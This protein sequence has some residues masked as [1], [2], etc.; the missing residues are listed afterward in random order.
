M[1]RRE[2]FEAWAKMNSRDIYRRGATVCKG[3]KSKSKTY[4]S[5][6]KDEH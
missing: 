3:Q 6:K 2:E 5:A 1:E 4:Y